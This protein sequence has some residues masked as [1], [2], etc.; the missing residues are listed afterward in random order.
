LELLV[1]P[2][3]AMLVLTALA[4]AL[5]TALAAA[6]EVVSAFSVEVLS[7][8]GVLL[9]PDSVEVSDEAAEVSDG[10]GVSTGSVETAALSVVGSAEGVSWVGESEAGGCS[11]S[12]VDSAAAEVLVST[13]LWFSVGM[14]AALWFSVGA[15]GD[16][17]SSA[18]WELELCK[19]ASNLSTHAPR[20]SEGA[21]YRHHSSRYQ[22]Y[23]RR[24]LPELVLKQLW[25]SQ[26]Y[27]SQTSRKQYTYPA[28]Q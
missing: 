16:V 19:R 15:A 10:P 12:S 20:S 24:V 22:C 9:D 8:S 23:S 27:L 1:V 5:V 13:E 14:G 4:L 17:S 21:T 25:L 3:L 18:L 26:P 2:L 28:L 11:P 6:A 7:E